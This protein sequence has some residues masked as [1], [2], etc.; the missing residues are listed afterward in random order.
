M[1]SGYRAS[2]LTLESYLHG[3]VLFAGDAA[4]LVPIFGVRGMNSAI[5]DAHNLAWK[6]ALTVQ[7]KAGP[8]LLESYS[9]ERVYAARENHRFANKSAEFMAPP[10]GTPFEAVLARSG[11]TV[12]VGADVS[13]LEAIEAAGVRAPYLCR[14]GACGQCELEVLEADG[15][16]LHHDHYLSDRDRAEGRKLMPCVS[17][18]RCRRLVLA[19]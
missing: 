13:L 9:T 10:S 4:H 2:A 1:P 6:L 12:Q 3:R 17:R 19:I 16:L 8:G 18:A 5:D 11:I 7:G 14:G 15:E